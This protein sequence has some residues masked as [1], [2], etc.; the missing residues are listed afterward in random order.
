MAWDDGQ[1]SDLLQQKYALLSAKNASDVTLQNAQAGGLNASTNLENVRAGL[2]PAAQ[3]ADIAKTGADT[4]LINT[5]AQ[6]L[7]ASSAADNFLK[8]ATGTNQFS[9]SN[10]TGQKTVGQTQLNGVPIATQIG[11][12]YQRGFPGA[13]NPTPLVTSGIAAPSPDRSPL[14]N[15]LLGLDGQS[16][17]VPGSGL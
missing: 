11:M 15:S 1:F 2:L 13:A 4:R 10:F 12:M 8:R 14:L 17:P 7:P 9:E 3:A 5:Q 6:V 16:R